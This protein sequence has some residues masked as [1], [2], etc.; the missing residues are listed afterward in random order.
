MSAEADA[1]ADAMVSALSGL[2][3]VDGGHAFYALFW[4]DMLWF[5]ACDVASIL[6]FRVSML[7]QGRR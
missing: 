1:D 6:I 4:R 2:E 3:R 5:Q 7:D